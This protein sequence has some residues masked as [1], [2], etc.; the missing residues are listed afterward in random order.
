VPPLDLPH[1]HGVGVVVPTG[2]SR[3]DQGVT[4]ADT[5][6]EVTGA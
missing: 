2:E 1:Y 3:A 6:K 4:A 5:A